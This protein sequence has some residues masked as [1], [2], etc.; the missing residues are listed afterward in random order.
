MHFLV[1]YSN[2]HLH[3]GHHVG[4]GWGC[5]VCTFVTQILR[6][7]PLVEILQCSVTPVFSRA[8]LRK[9]P[10]LT[11]YPYSNIALQFPAICHFF[12][13]LRLSQFVLSLANRHKLQRRLVACASDSHWHCVSI[14]PFSKSNGA[15]TPS[16]HSTFCGTCFDLLI[17][18]LMAPLSD[19][20]P[21]LALTAGV[22]APIVYF[23]C[24]SPLT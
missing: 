1:Q 10:Q 23:R 6:H 19:C 24:S 17:F 7:K 2:R 8:F 11:H 21:S 22:I 13:S 12:P 3:N 15:V 16:Y 4:M 5:I 9:V 14:S 18:W 20:S